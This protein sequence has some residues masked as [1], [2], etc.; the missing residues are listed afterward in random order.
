M[1]TSSNLFNRRILLKTLADLSKP[2][3]HN[4]KIMLSVTLSDTLSETSFVLRDSWSVAPTPIV[5]STHSNRC[6][7][8]RKARNPDT[9]KWLIRKFWDRRWTFFFFGFHFF[10]AGS[11]FFHIQ[12][13]AITCGFG[14]SLSFAS[15]FLLHG[16][17]EAL[18]CAGG[19]GFVALHRSSVMDP[20][21][22]NIVP[23]WTGSPGRRD[24]LLAMP[25][26]SGT[27]NRPFGHWDG[28][29]WR[30]PARPQR[31]Y[32]SGDSDVACEPSRQPAMFQI[33]L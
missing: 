26:A 1:K 12:F 23:V 33:W 5:H 2:G 14:R 32:E 30:T 13:S 29:A 17:S 16:L 19:S 31:G 8:S 4:L 3:K 20:P 6:R 25:R 27:Y 28:D 22:N 11:F 24:S 10:S 21:H 7:A 9:E 15:G 18:W